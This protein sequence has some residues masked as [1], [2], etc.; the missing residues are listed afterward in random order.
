MSWATIYIGGR[1][2]FQEAIISKLRGM[3]LLG[4]PEAIDDLIMFWLPENFTE[5]NLKISLGSKL[6]FK[7]RLQFISNLNCHLKLRREE[8]TKFSVSE[9]EMIDNM[10]N[11]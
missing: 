9:N 1:N 2:G 11:G 7:Y 3:W 4:S 8:L 10:I 5:R 6:I